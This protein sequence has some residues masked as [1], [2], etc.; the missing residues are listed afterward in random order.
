MKYVRIIY[1]Y[2]YIY[3]YVCLYIEK[4]Y[5]ETKINYTEKIMQK[6]KEIIIAVKASHIGENLGWDMYILNKK[7][8]K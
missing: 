2:I 8:R 6:I 5:T 7:G 3:I 1:I 4:R